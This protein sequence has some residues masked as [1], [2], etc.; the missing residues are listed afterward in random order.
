M[1]RHWKLAGV[2]VL[3]LAYT[4][5][6]VGCS[7]T[8][9]PPYASEQ[10][11]MLLEQGVQAHQQGRYSEAMYLFEQASAHYRSIDNQAAL[12]LTLLNFAETA[13][14]VGARERA[15]RVAHDAADLAKAKEELNLYW[16]AK[17]LLARIQF[18]EDNA[19][20][21]LEYVE[22][23]LT[24]YDNT[25]PLYLNALILRADIAFQQDANNT[26]WLEQVQ[27]MPTSNPLYQARV[28]RLN[29]LYHVAHSPHLAEHE[30][31]AAHN[32]YRRLTFRPGIASTL[33]QLSELYATQ[34]RYDE[35]KQVG[36][37][38]LHVRAWLKDD[39]G[40]RQLLLHLASVSDLQG[41]QDW[42]EQAR[43]LAWQLRIEPSQI[44][45]PN[46]L[47]ALDKI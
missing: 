14:L 2:F 20:H 35:A 30:L 10:S 34:A 3:S 42:A 17:L 27:S 12:A 28:L 43:Q 26:L 40:A 47:D 44:R 6:A 22:E 13:Y 33:T 4:A 37:R 32:I 24:L 15:Y 18:E 41:K 31:N 23:F 9:P 46:F 16:R 5:T 7:K 38:A 1:N 39:H 8:P 29:A 25:S 11:N 36:L 45:N 19:P 21:A